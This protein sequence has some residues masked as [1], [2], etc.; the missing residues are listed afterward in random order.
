MYIHLNSFKDDVKNENKAKLLLLHKKNIDLLPIPLQGKRF[1]FYDTKVKGLELMVTDKAGK[2]FKVYRTLQGKPIRI[3]LGHYPNMTVEYARKK[4]KQLITQIAQGINPNHEKRKA[5]Q[6]ITFADLFD[7]FMK[8]HSKKHK[9]TWKSDERDIPRFTQQWFQRQ[10]S[11]ISKQD[12]QALH[13]KIKEQ[14]GLYQANRLLS[15]IQVMYGK[16][17]EWGYEGMNPTQGIKKFKEQS[18][19]RFLHTDE[20][21][22]FLKALEGESNETIRDYI[23][24]SL[25]TGARKSNVL[26]MR[27]GDINLNRKEWLIPETKN[28]EPLRIPLTNKVIEILEKRKQ[29]NNGTQWVFQGHGKT[30]HLIDPKVAW[31]RILESAE[32]TDFR[33][34]DL[35]RTFGSWQAAAGSNSFTIGKSLGH[36]S[37]QST[38][39]YARVDIDAVRSSVETATQA[40]M[41]HA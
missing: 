26:A 22:R 21:G 9:K 32:I 20:M 18:R 29:S 31:K 10:I 5:K 41:T 33:I 13:R 37:I 23:Y 19:E 7:R 1:Y 15:R 11:N 14:N 24:I 6:E 40:I 8:D 2:S 30:G 25:L 39:I 35:R 38:A 3:T 4:A 36:K 34:H 28:G 12:V 17:I 16:A 27:W